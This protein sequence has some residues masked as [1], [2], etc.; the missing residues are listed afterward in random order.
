MPPEPLEQLLW[1]RSPC[2]DRLRDM[3][4]GVDAGGQMNCAF[5]SSSTRGIVALLLCFQSGPANAEIHRGNLSPRSFF[6]YTGSSLNSVM[7]NSQYFI[8]N[9]GR[10]D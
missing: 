2:V 4:G 5:W 6:T 9:K 10:R 8:K 3:K 1:N 7:Q